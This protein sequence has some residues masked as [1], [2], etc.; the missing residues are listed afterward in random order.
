[1]R[2]LKFVLLCFPLLSLG[3]NLVGEWY[4]SK[5]IDEGHEGY[6]LYKI[7]ENEDN[8]HYGN[9]LQLKEDGTFSSFYS[10]PCGNDCFPSSFGIYEI[11]EDN[12][13]H[14]F[15]KEFNQDG[16]CESIHKVLD[17]SLGDF[18]ISKVDENT[19]QLIKVI[20]SKTSTQKSSTTSFFFSNSKVS[21]IWVS[22]VFILI[23]VG[24]YIFHVQK[25]IN[26]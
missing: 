11:K 16:M 7:E 14:L 24:Y 17:K 2:I 9:I 1:M 23:I 22:L 19:I 13:I 18:S 8:P 15:I 10:A 25:R 6:T 21:W 5:I 12:R 4:V 3:Q 26:K 20:E